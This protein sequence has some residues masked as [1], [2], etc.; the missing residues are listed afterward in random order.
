MEPMPDTTIE[1]LKAY[2][3]T[4]EKRNVALEQANTKLNAKMHWLEERFRLA[5]KQHYGASSERSHPD[6]LSLVFDEA[7]VI[8]KPE[9]PEPTMETITYKRRKKQQG[10]RAKLL[11]DLPVERVEYEI[12]ESDRV[13]GACEGSMHSMSTEVRRELKVVPAQVKVIEHVRLPFMR[14]R[15]H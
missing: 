7:E 1:Q 5:M 14:T 6:Q 11:K 12:P 15:K 9:A 8:A 4:L 3:A 13:C 10:Q 2:V